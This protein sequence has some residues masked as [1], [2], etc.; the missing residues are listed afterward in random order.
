MKFTIDTEAMLKGLTNLAKVIP[1]HPVLPV[2]SNFLF[3]LRGEEL[4]LAAMDGEMRLKTIL[5]VESPEGEGSAAVP[6]KIFMDLL[7]TLPSKGFTIEFDENGLLCTWETGRS[8][9]P[10]FQAG[11]FPEFRG[12]DPESRK[13][14]TMHGGDIST[15]IGKTVFAVSRNENQ[16]VLCG[17]F[18]DISH[19]GSA[20]VATDTHKLVVQNVNTPYAEEGE[21]ILSSRAA[22]VL[23]EIVSRDDALAVEYDGRCAIF[24]TRIYELS[25]VTVAGKYPR[26]RTVI[27]EGNE[28][29][30]SVERTKLLDVLKRM[31]V[32]A[33]QRSSII[34]VSL[35]FNEM[36]LTA[37][38]L[39][40]QTF[41][42]ES[43]EC[44]YDGDDMEIGFKAP[45]FIET[46]SSMDAD[47]IEIRFKE[48]RKAILLQP[49]AEERKDEPFEAVLM[50]VLVG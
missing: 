42:T 10:V 45:F 38:D 33:D 43:L 17:L 18:F 24:R 14:F 35:S 44:D 22:K 5:K 47:G 2:L 49:S 3:T 15:A 25:C 26:Y 36:N 34:K 11:D 29:I 48:P 46:V 9:L 12:P 20:I 6:A 13:R 30:L 41:A 4:T 39:E 50:P 23:K 27:P 21:F 31:S 28:N 8:T 16:P 37:Q 1:A 19:D 40:M 7:K 32:C